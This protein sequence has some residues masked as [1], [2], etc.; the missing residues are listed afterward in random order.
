MAPCHRVGQCGIVEGEPPADKVATAVRFWCGALQP[1][2]RL[3][4][5]QSRPVLLPHPLPSRF[6]KPA[7]VKL[8]VKS[9]PHHFLILPRGA[10]LKDVRVQGVV[11]NAPVLRNELE[12]LARALLIED[13]F[14]RGEHAAERGA[15]VACT[16]VASR[17]LVVSLLVAVHPVRIRRV[18]IPKDE[19][20]SEVHAWRVRRR[21]RR[22]PGQGRRPKRRRR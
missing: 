22:R 8:V 5:I 20:G 19:D 6:G 21:R 18:C 7:L 15:R 11:L 10:V 4:Q 14:W 1:A 9:E 2:I 16:G 3:I 13:S 12:S 17:R